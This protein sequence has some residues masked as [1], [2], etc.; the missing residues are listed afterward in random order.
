M[1]TMYVDQVVHMDTTWIF[2][3]GWRW[4][5]YGPHAVHIPLFKPRG[6]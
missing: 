5:T 6:K 2:G 1:W 4:S 3:G